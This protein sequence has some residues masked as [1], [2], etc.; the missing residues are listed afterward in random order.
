LCRLSNL[1]SNVFCKSVDEL[2]VQGMADLYCRLAQ[3]GVAGYHYVSNSPFN[4]FPVLT[5]F[6]ATHPFPRGFSLKLK[7]YGGGN[8]INGLFEPAGE[9]K[10]PGII[11][12]MDSFPRAKFVLIGDSGEQDLELYVAIARERPHQVLAILIRDVTSAF[13][14][15]RKSA[16]PPPRSSTAAS[17]SSKERPSA[18]DVDLSALNEALSEEPEAMNE[19]SSLHVSSDD[20]SVMNA[21]A[22]DMAKKVVKRTRSWDAPRM[23]LMSR[24]SAD[25]G[26]AK[27]GRV[28]NGRTNLSR[29]TS[30]STL[31]R[32]G[33][34]SAGYLPDNGKSTEDVFNEMIEDVGATDSTGK[35]ASA[36]TE[37]LVETQHELEVLTTQ[38]LKLQRR[39]EEWV[40]RMMLAQ[41][42]LPPD[43][44]LLFFQ[45][46]QEIEETI[47]SKVREVVEHWELK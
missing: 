10:R 24:M 45:Q 34:P 23:T 42:R 19:S 8:L 30:S 14:A 40:T 4:L 36:S 9:R 2:A 47:A 1:Y 32:A 7:Y 33:V 18:S 31:P 5:D 21:K 25:S 16:A 27:E 22:K 15:R 38:Q 35:L 3:E 26:N 28:D 39:A 29:S 41:R 6:F 20:A 12:V 13:A 46:P 37:E 17:E 44:M 11:E 43:I